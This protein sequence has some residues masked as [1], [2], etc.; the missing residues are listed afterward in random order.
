VLLGLAGNDTLTSLHGMDT[1]VGGLGNDTYLVTTGDVIVEQ[2]GEGTDTVRSGV[3][4]VLGDNLEKLVLTGSDAINATGNSLNNSLTGNSAANVLDGGGG[5]DTM[6]GAGGNDTY[7]VDST[8]DRVVE[9]ANAGI[10]TVISTIDYKLTANVENLTLVGTAPLRG[11]GNSLSNV[12]I[13]NDGNN[14]I[15]GASGSDT[16]DGGA[17]NDVIRGGTGDDV[18]IGG[19]GID[20]MSGG[21][22]S[23]VFVFNAVTDSPAGTGR[24]AISDFTRGQDKI[25]LSAIDADLI[26]DGH[27]S[28]LFVGANAFSGTAG[29]LRF[30]SGLL[31]ADAN[32]DGVADVEIAIRLTSGS[33]LSLSDF[34]L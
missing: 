16:L 13:G 24:D 18:I 4:W 9:A 22:G 11:T 29:E 14:V 21:K 8:G 32:G 1:L 31:Q 15:D 10:D 19:A 3:T 20:Q 27:Q 23:D 34:R 2:T 17:G 26:H 30:S 12:I 28:Y 7:M 33:S 25:D 5:N 6:A